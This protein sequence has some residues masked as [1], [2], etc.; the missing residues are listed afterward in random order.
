[1]NDLGPECWKPTIYPLSIYSPLSDRCR[2]PRPSHAGDVLR[3]LHR[4]D[5]LRPIREKTQFGWIP[6]LAL[7]RSKSMPIRFVMTPALH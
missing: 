5:L 6:T 2:R 3:M 7:G 1:M 4:S